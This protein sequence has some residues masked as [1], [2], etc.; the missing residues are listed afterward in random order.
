MDGVRLDEV[1][2]DC[3]IE[4]G[5]GLHDFFITNVYTHINMC[6]SIV[7]QAYRTHTSKN[8]HGVRMKRVTVGWCEGG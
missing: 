6:I 8:T 5:V 2:A 3:V 4:N 1:R 7:T